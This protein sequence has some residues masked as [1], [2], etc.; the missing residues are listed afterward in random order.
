MV[1]ICSLTLH[2]SFPHSHPSGAKCMCDQAKAQIHQVN[3][4]ACWCSQEHKVMDIR[5]WALVHMHILIYSPGCT[6]QTAQAS[7]RRL[8]AM[9]PQPCNLRRQ[10]HSHPHPWL[11][12]E[13]WVSPVTAFWK[14]R[15]YS[16]LCKY[17]QPAVHQWR[18]VELVPANRKL[19]LEHSI[20][21]TRSTQMEDR[22]PRQLCPAT[23]DS[24]NSQV[25][26]SPS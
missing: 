7:L 23:L 13:M 19:F 11:A 22:N 1:S 4:L 21:C 8:S 16:Q 25:T 20:W 5:R 2:L 10:I 9:H 17:G 18:I 6:I 26:D 14:V 3:R 24:E 12:I 15:C